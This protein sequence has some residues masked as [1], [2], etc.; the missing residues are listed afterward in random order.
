M[1]FT[2]GIDALLKAQEG[3]DPVT[4]ES[5]EIIRGMLSGADPALADCLE[6]AVITAR[7]ASRSSSGTMT[8]HSRSSRSPRRVW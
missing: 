8:A 1:A 7:L 6:A 2:P 4:R 3:L 5:I